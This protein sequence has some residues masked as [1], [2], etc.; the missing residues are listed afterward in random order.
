MDDLTPEEVAA[1]EATRKQKEAMKECADEINA[2]LEKH[3]FVINIVA[4]PQMNLVPKG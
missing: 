2:V 4:N 3:G 1:I